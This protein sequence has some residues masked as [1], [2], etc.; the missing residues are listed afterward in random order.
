GPGPEPLLRPPRERAAAAPAS[1]RAPHPQLCAARPQPEY[2]EAT[3]GSPNRRRRSCWRCG[4]PAPPSAD[5]GAGPGERGDTEAALAPPSLTHFA[6]APVPG[7]VP[8]GGPGFAE[9]PE[10]P[11]GP[12]PEQRW[13][14]ECLRAQSEG[15][16]APGPGWWAGPWCPP[17]DAGQGPPH[18]LLSAPDVPPGQHHGPPGRCAL[19]SLH[20][21]RPGHLGH[22]RPEPGGAPVWADAPGAGLR[23]LPHRAAVPRQRCHHGGECQLWAHRR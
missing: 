9:P 10:R 21:C 8:G 3:A 13:S 4:A 6:P 23:R 16:A 2:P 22:P 14:G 5:G 15:D 19:E 1:S 17:G 18:R 20:Y 12:T 7:D 11:A